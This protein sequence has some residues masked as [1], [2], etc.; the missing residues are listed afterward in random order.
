MESSELKFKRVWDGVTLA[1]LEPV[2]GMGAL[3]GA[4]RTVSPG[5]LSV[6]EPMTEREEGGGGQAVEIGGEREAWPVEGGRASATAGIVA[7]KPARYRR[8]GRFGGSGN[9]RVRKSFQNVLTS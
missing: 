2:K 4:G 7:T 9:L 5:H 6:V 1:N 3:S 8:A